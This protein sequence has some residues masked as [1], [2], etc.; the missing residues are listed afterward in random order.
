MV[1]HEKLLGT[2]KVAWGYDEPLQGYFLA[3]TDDRLAW[4]EGQST[5]VSKVVEKVSQD[6]GGHYFDLHTYPVGG[7]G[8]KVTK[9]TIFTFM[10][11]Y[12]IDP[13]K[14]RSIDETHGEH[15]KEC[16]Y[17][18]CRLPETEGL[19]M[20]KR[21]ARCKNA[22]YCSRACQVADWKSHKID[23]KEAE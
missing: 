17:H 21:C 4:R 11:R 8:H 18:G 6:S 23:C 5:E 12:D 20:H 1:R 9:E 14:I 16:A 2:T 19:T 3:I 22:R 7:F 15:I 13:E 10:R